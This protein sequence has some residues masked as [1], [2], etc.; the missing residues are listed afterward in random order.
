MKGTIGIAKLGNSP[1]SVA[2]ALSASGNISRTKSIT[3]RASTSRPW[4]IKVTVI[5]AANEEGI[6]VVILG[7]NTM[8][9]IVNAVRPSMM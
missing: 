9:A 2:V 4:T 7:N 1:A 5:I 8:I 3:V 6:A